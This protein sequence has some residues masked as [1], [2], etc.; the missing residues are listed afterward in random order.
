MGTQ[1]SLI[2]GFFVFAFSQFSDLSAQADS[3]TPTKQG[4]VDTLSTLTIKKERGAFYSGKGVG[5]TEVL[6][7]NEFKKA[8]CCTLSESFELSNTVEVSN[9]DGV[10]GIKQVEMLGLAGK[11]VLMSRENIPS[12]NGLA[13][14]NGLSNIPGP[15]VSSVHLAKGAGSATLGADGLTGG[16]NYQMKADIKDP[17]LYFNAYSNHQ[18]RAE[19]N[20]IVKTIAANRALS[21]TYLHSGGQYRTTDMGDDGLADMPLS[22][23]YFISNHTQIPGKKMESQFGFLGYQDRKDGGSLKAGSL[24]EIS[25]DNS[26]MRF[27][28]EEQHIEG[29]AKLGIFLSKNGDRSIGNI[30]NVSRH[31]LGSLLNSLQGRNYQGQEDRI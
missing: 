24:T 13:T 15:M 28:F 14:L 22:Q 2:A 12:I 7:E 17:R 19:A 20:V 26:A 16:L 5:L 8:A 27:D 4:N 21:H 10:S 31:K 11:Y 6:T 9:A 23:R 25:N 1:S 30:F 18:G 3:L 29:Y